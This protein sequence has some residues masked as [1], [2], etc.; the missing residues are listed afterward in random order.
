MELF[1]S[2]CDDYN[3]DHNKETVSASHT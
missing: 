2:F 1:D 3:D